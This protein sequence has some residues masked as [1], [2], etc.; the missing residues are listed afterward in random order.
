[1]VP[2]VQKEFQPLLDYFVHGMTISISC[3]KGIQDD[4]CS[5]IVPMSLRVPHLLSAVLALAAAHRQSSGL[6]E[7]DCQFELMK[8]R[9]LKQLR[10]ALT[11]FS[12]TDNDQ[13][14]ATTLILCMAEVISPTSAVSS[15]RSHLY[16]AATL[17]SQHSTSSGCSQSS[18]S[19]FLRRKFQALQAIALACGAQSY[20]GHILEA[21]TGQCDAHIDD[22]AGYSTNLFPIFQEINNL[23]RT[24]DFPDPEFACDSPPG[25]P[26]FDCTS[27]LEHKSHLLFDRIRALMAQRKLP[28]SQNNGGLP[29][30]TSHELYLLDEAYHHMALLQ[31]SRRGSLSVPLQVI[32]DSRQSILACLTAITYQSGPCPGVAALPPLFVAGTLCTNQSDRDM[33]RGLLK[34]LWMNYGMGN[35]RSCQTVLQRWWKY[36]DEKLSRS[37]LSELHSQHDEQEGAYLCDASDLAWAAVDHDI[38]PY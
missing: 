11:Q 26:H 30:V 18:T 4:I 15:W 5:T 9:S 25:P 37:T 38:L 29:W 22:L 36:Q 14:L 6:A 17:S 21:A 8:G 2:M 7:G 32:K 3:H 19:A 23:E 33:V 16:G 20:D 1:M 35:V 28:E 24:Q 10:S 34:A 12:P 13:I 27:P 31:V